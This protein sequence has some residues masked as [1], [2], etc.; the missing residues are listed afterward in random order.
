MRHENMHTRLFHQRPDPLNVLNRNLLVYVRTEHPSRGA[1]VRDLPHF[2]LP[3]EQA[4]VVRGVTPEVNPGSMGRRSG[5]SIDMAR[6]MSRSIDEVQA[7]VAEVVHCLGERA[8][9]SGELGV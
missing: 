2:L 1:R 7:A 4:D 9:G 6:H 5:E 3:G 8:N